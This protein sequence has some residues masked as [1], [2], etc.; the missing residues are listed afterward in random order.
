MMH[1]A[2][3]WLEVAARGGH[4]RAPY[5]LGV[6]CARGMAGAKDFVAAYTWF[7]VAA[8]I[9]GDE[10]A[11]KLAEAVGGLLTAEELEAAKDLA[12][13]TW[14]EIGAK[15]R[16]TAAGKPGDEEARTTEDLEDVIELPASQEPSPVRVEDGDTSVHDDPQPL[17]VQ[18][19]D[20]GAILNDPA[21][22]RRPL[23]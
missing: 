22:G 19:I 10:R 9:T 1:E 5:R 6:V 14:Q 13:R 11:L 4:P 15:V 18:D 17:W 12:R 23:M 2:R 3:Y 8:A 20:I 7:Y 16:R 21:E